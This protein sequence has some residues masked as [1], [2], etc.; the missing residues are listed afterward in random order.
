MGGSIVKLPQIVKI[1]RGKSAR[2]LSLASYLLD[3]GSLVITVAY[4]IRHEFPWSTYGENVFL[5]LQ[6]VSCVRTLRLALWL[7]YAP[8]S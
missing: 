6:N 3:T 4:N 8:R 1:V 2:G 7:T 5:L